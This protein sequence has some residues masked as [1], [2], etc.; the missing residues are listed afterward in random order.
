MERWLLDGE[1]MKSVRFAPFVALPLFA[2]GG[3]HAPA[4]L[5]GGPPPDAANGHLDVGD[6]DLGATN[7]DLGDDCAAHPDPTSCMAGGC[8]W[9]PQPVCDP[10]GPCNPTPPCRST[11]DAIHN[12][13]DCIARADCHPLFTSDENCNNICCS[14][15]FERCAQGY[16][17]NCRGPA[18]CQTLSPNCIGPFVVAYSATCHAGCVLISECA[19]NDYSQTQDSSC[20]SGWRDRIQLENGTWRTVCDPG[21][22]IPPGAAISCPAR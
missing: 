11:C 9:V 16:E 10:P 3:C 18:G 2:L 6:P 14:S 5:N 21:K 20:P 7:A 13:N 4:L 17:A 8:A 22:T 19:P 1:R 12:G 15:H